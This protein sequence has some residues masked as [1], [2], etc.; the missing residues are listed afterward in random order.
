MLAQPRGSSFH[1]TTLSDKTAER[2]FGPVSASKS[3]DEG[4]LGV[5]LARL[6]PEKDWQ[7]WSPT[8]P[9]RPDH[10]ACD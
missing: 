2:V 5:S 4:G 6:V 10:D 7:F 3:A 9:F 8:P 1:A